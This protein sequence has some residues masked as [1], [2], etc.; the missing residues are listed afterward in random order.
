MGV[1]FHCIEFTGYRQHCVRQLRDFVHSIGLTE[2]RIWFCE[3]ERFGGA[4][5]SGS[6]GEPCGGADQPESYWQLLVSHSRHWK[7]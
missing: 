7:R 2:N 6:A 4:L 3:G 1:A 5:S